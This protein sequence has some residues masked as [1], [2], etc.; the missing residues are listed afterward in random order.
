MRAHNAAPVSVH[1]LS[2]EA[3]RHPLPPHRIS[4]TRP[5]ALSPFL[6]ALSSPGSEGSRTRVHSRQS[7]DQSR[8]A[9]PGLAGGSS[10]GAGRARPPPHSPS[11]TAARG[12]RGRCCRYSVHLSRG[13]QGRRRQQSTARTA[14]PT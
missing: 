3:L 7:H 4:C 2:Q 8:T 1:P 10:R 9:G 13:L 14:K 11:Q 12:R 5:P 6:R